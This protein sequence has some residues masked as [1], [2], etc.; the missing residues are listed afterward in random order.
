MVRR[1]RAFLETGHYR[2]LLEELKRRVPPS[3]LAQHGLRSLLDV[4]CGEG[5]FTAGLAEALA[6]WEVW[7]IDISRDA[8]D[9]AARRHPEVNFAVAAARDLPI[10]DASVDVAVSTFG[11]HEPGEL[12]R[13][14]R[15]GG[16]LLVASPGARPAGGASENALPR[17]PAAWP[18]SGRGSPRRLDPLIISAGEA[19]GTDGTE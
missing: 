12:R 18:P 15:P 1:R 4:G 7:G 13:V 5:Y 19:N 11:P 16:R 9:V 8:V 14:L 3:H 6:G 17:R 2:P 10:L